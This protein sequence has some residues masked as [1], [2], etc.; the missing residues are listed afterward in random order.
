VPGRRL[1]R[2]LDSEAGRT[3]DSVLEVLP[4]LY[5]ISRTSVPG[6]RIVRDLDSEAGLSPDSV[7]QVLP[8]LGFICEST[9]SWISEGGS[10][11][12]GRLTGLE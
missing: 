2:N 12:T 1:A 10:P 8:E 6:R 3:S 5:S 11:N 9:G 7:L 4:E